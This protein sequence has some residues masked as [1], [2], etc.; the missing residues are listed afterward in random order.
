M[1]KKTNRKA[2]TRAK[3]QECSQR[4]FYREPGV[5]DPARLSFPR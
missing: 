5:L 1:T 4:T 3:E 2:K